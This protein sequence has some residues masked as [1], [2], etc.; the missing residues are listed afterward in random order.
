MATTVAGANLET[1]DLGA[2]AKSND[3]DWL[4]PFAI[5]VAAEILIARTIELSLTYSLLALAGAGALAI[6]WL[7]L[8]VVRSIQAGLDRPVATL[9][10]IIWANR[11]RLFC[12]VIGI[13]IAA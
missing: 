3:V 1:G 4:V 8:W 2:K 5:V 13:E 12:T 9:T 6:G 7:L 11:T 10:N